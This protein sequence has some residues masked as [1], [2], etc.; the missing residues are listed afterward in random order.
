MSWCPCAF[1]SILLQRL[2][3][4]ARKILVQQ[5]FLTGGTKNFYQ[6]FRCS[7]SFKESY[8]HN[9]RLNYIFKIFGK[10]MSAILHPTCHHF[11]SCFYFNSASTAVASK[12]K[13]LRST[14]LFNG[15]HK[16]LSSRGEQWAILKRILHS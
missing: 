6:E 15:R 14:I 5:Y 3:Q 11:Q 8:S 12:Q 7:Q 2:L 1:T 13:N 16:E 10:K 4:T 9:L